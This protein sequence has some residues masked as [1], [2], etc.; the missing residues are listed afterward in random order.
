MKMIKISKKDL[1]TIPNI[2]SYI[3]ILLVPIFVYV[4]L[5]AET[6]EDYFIS[7]IVV[8]LSSLTD[9]FDGL[10]ARKCNM[11]TELGKVLDPVADKL[12]QAAMLLVLLI[13]IDWMIWIVVLFII[14]EAFMFFA[15]LFMLK[16]GR[17]LDGA[18]WYGKVSTAVLYVVMIIIIAMPNIGNG[19]MQCLM[20][21]SAILLALSF[22]M[23]ALEYV[24]MYR[25]IR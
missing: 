24:K 1:V 25:S 5:T 14:K 15:G 9:C 4:Y 13:K 21:I 22:I 7:A 11:I 10:I 16:K 3:R 23:Y 19:I 17:K 12:M 6:S 18:K 8:L 20:T 2:L